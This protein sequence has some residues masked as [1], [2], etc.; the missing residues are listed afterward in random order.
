MEQVD[1]TVAR[2]ITQTSL[3]NA[4]ESTTLVILL[5]ISMIDR[6]KMLRFASSKGKGGTLTTRTRRTPG[7]PAR[8]P[9]TRGN[10]RCLA[11]SLTCGTA[12]E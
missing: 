1:G 12:I 6:T 11:F 7:S 2:H 10:M 4:R 8:T 3:P 5:W 9:L